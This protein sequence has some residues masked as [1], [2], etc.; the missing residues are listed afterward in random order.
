M[1]S[2]ITH[3]REI[4]GPE[5]LGLEDVSQALGSASET[6]PPDA[7]RLAAEVPFSTADL[8][9]AAKAG[10]SLIFRLGADARGPWTIQRLIERFPAAFEPRSLT[11]V[12]YA[13]RDEWGISM[14][15]LTRSETCPTGWSLV[16]RA[17]LAASLNL[18]YF[19]QDAVLRRFAAGD[20]RVRR[21]TAVEATYDLLVYW[22]ARGER[23][24][25]ESYDWTS[26]RTIDAGYLYVGGFA[27]EGLTVIGFSAAVRHATLGVCPTRGAS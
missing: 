14:E 27:E 4:L 6:L 1:A 13:L 23:L 11:Q 22:T 8:E 15:P 19:Q 17:P 24:L 20:A 26:S 12:G 10:Q 3:A 18:S 16:R 21:R 2:T 5:V 25:A 7:R 9:Q